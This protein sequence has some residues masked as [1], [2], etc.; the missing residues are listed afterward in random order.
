METL[1]CIDF[2]SSYTKVA[3]R[4]KWNEPTTPLHDLGWTR[5]FGK[6]SIDRCVY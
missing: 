3:V 5:A 4:H 2:G 1:I 6:H